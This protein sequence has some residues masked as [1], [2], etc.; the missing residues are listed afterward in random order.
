MID[1][2]LYHNKNEFA[3]N[4]NN[5]FI[6]FNKKIL[7]VDVDINHELKYKKGLVILDLLNIF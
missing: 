1:K 5:V 7:G 4:I 3:N 6:Q 2:L